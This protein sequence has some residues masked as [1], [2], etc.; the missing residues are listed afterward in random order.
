M[1]FLQRPNLPDR[2]VKGVIVDCRADTETI[3]RLKNLGIEPVLSYCS[4]NLH[5]AICSHPDMTIIHVGGNR[6]ICAPDAYNY[7]KSTLPQAEIIKGEVDIKPEYPYDVAYNITL[8]GDFTFMNDSTQQVK[9]VNNGKIVNIRQGYTKCSICIVSENAI[10][11]ADTGI[12]RAARDNNIDALMIS[13]G[14]IE[15]PG[16]NYGFIGGSTGLIAPDTL[17]VNGDMAAHPD[18]EVITRFCASHDVKIVSLKKGKI[19]DI[20]SILPIY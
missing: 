10:I 14:N 18:G 19:R 5:P 4:K 15:L 9:V 20:G 16:M 7:Y 11:T 12:Y 17:A 3:E 8:L 2:P 1:G 6:F 13:A